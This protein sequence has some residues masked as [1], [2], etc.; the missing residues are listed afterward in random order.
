MIL[1]E[2]ADRFREVA[3]Q[4]PVIGVLGPRQSGKTTLVRKVFSKHRYI[5]LEDID[6]RWY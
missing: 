6:N 2:L 4:F 1:R 3:L 5:S